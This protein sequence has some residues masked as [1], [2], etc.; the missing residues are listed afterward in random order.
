LTSVATGIVGNVAKI[1]SYGQAVS[2]PFVLSEIL[3]NTTNGEVT[4]TI[5][6]TDPSIGKEYTDVL[7]DQLFPLPSQPA[8]AAQPAPTQAANPTFNLLDDLLA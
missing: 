5:K 3:I 4:G 2:G 6:C 7:G 1:Y 8:Q